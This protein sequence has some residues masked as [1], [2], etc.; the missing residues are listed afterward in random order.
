M[1][2]NDLHPISAHLP[3]PAESNI[4]MPY[5]QTAEGSEFWGSFCFFCW[6]G[7]GG[8]LF[9]GCL[10]YNIIQ[11]LLNKRIFLDVYLFKWGHEFLDSHVDCHLAQGVARERERT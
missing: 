5:L 4:R 11:I 10:L 6:G 3:G 8:G 7:G 1:Y 9:E 2:M